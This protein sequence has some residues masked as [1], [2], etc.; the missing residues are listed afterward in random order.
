MPYVLPV[1]QVGGGSAGNI[2]EQ[3]AF[4]LLEDTI[5]WEAGDSAAN[6][7]TLCYAPDGGLEATPEGIT[8]GECITLLRDP[9][10]LPQEV[11]D[12]F[13]HLADLP[14]LKIDPNDIGMV[15]DILKGQFAVS[16]INAQGVHQGESVRRKGI[17]IVAVGG[18]LAAALPAMVIGNDAVAIFQ[19]LDLISKHAGAPQ[20][21]VREND[22]FGAFAGVFV[23][24]F[25]AVG[26]EVGHGFFS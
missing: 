10:G 23:V 6:T 15:P 9:N 25:Y 12:K 20:Q 14:A 3:R 17:H 19:M 26:G 7:Y 18:H 1:P 4:W 11:Q 24:E 21:A 13:P 2:N 22:G 5:A 8:G 16:A